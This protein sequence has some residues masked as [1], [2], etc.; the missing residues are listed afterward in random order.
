MVR[1]IE[2]LT[3]THDVSMPRMLYV[4]I[5]IR[6][7][8]WVFDSFKTGI[9]LENTE[10]I[11]NTGNVYIFLKFVFEYIKQYIIHQSDHS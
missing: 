4:A 3:V 5:Y 2:C 10:I 11:L 6:M 7:N 9:R 8:K 1:Q